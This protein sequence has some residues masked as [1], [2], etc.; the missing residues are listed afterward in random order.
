MRRIRGIAA[1][2]AIAVVLSMLLTGCDAYGQFFGQAQGALAANSAL[3]DLVD[4]LRTEPGVED[5]RYTLDAFAVSGDPTALVTV[6]LG[7]EDV[8]GWTAVSGVVRDGADAEALAGVDVYVTFQHEGGLAFSVDARLLDADQLRAEVM[9]ALR[10]QTAL[11]VPVRVELNGDASALRRVV[12]AVTDGLDPL[13]R[14]ADDAVRAELDAAPTLASG[15]GWDVPGLTTWEGLPTA[16]RVRLLAGLL[17]GLPVLG[18]SGL[19]ASEPP[20]LAAGATWALPP[21]GQE[22]LSLAVFELDG[23]EAR[24]APEA[25]ALAGRALLMDGVAA[26]IQYLT[27]DGLHFGNL[28][29]GVCP[30]QPLVQE[31][32]LRFA[33]ALRAHGAAV[34]ERSVGTCPVPLD[35][36]R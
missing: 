12:R 26:S 32:D 9:S 18:Y 16:D 20:A 11:E 5:A 17:D 31:Q 1:T 35:P 23:D 8:D 4:E 15:T 3:D 22:S 34:P 30:E 29:V 14:L 28:Y 7:S 25:L 6:D 10:I 33:A 24:P 19:T 13:R 27:D 21:T 2:A 36:S